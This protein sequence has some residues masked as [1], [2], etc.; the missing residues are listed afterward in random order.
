MKHIRNLASCL[1]D[2]A[3]EQISSNYV[4]KSRRE[5]LETRFSSPFLKNRS[6]MKEQSLVGATDTNDQETQTNHQPL[7]SFGE[8]LEPEKPGSFMTNTTTPLYGAGQVDNGSMDMKDTTS[9]Y[10]TTSM[11]PLFPSSIC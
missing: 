4:K 10:S 1:A 3:N 11:E 8:N 6:G 2:L 5:K 9:H 7:W